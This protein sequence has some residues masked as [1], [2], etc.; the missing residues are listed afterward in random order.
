MATGTKTCG[1]TVSNSGRG[2]LTVIDP[3][4]YAYTNVDPNVWPTRRNIRAAR[5]DGIRNLLKRPMGEILARDRNNGTRAERAAG[6]VCGQ[7]RQTNDSP[8]EVC[9]APIGAFETAGNLT[10][11]M[12]STGS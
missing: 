8:N 2:Q 9:G 12:T 5:P 7:E 10:P 4:H 11:R 3:V 6:N 1:A